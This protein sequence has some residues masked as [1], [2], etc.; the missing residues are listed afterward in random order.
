MHSFKLNSVNGSLTHSTRFVL[1]DGKG[2]IRG[3]YATLEDGFLS[4]FMHD[5][6]QLH[7]EPQS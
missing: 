3:Y 7:H 1:V 6:R 4:K 2:R 5:L